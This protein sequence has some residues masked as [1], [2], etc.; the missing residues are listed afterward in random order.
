MPSS[1][2]STQAKQVGEGGDII[3][4][5]MWLCPK[6]VLDAFFYRKNTV[7]K[8]FLEQESLTTFSRYYNGNFSLSL[9]TKIFFFVS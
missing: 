4:N 7:Y 2:M 5:A 3:F 9:N 8:V 6:Q 1:K